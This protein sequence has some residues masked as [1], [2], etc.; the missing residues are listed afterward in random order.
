M[1]VDDV[2]DDDVDDDGSAGCDDS[3]GM[4]C[5]FFSKTVRQASI[6]DNEFSSSSASAFNAISSR[7]L[8]IC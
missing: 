4:D 5:N 2:V 3:R 1:A 7:C 6:M 8:A